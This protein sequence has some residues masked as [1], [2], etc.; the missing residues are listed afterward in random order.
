MLLAVKYYT[1]TQQYNTADTAA[2][3]SIISCRCVLLSSLYRPTLLQLPLLS[4]TTTLY[5]EPQ[6][7]WLISTSYC[8][9]LL[10]QLLY[11]IYPGAKSTAATVTAAVTLTHSYRET[12]PA[13]AAATCSGCRSGTC[14]APIVAQAVEDITQR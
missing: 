6:Q 4:T 9:A 8:A 7:A 11:Y 2:L 12:A 10:A 5:T 3:A 14:A 13:A 1:T